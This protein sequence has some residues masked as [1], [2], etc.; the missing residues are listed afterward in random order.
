MYS[1]KF[2][3]S[4]SLRRVFVG[5]DIVLGPNSIL[6]FGPGGH[7]RLSKSLGNGSRRNVETR[8]F[9]RESVT[10]AVKY[11]ARIAGPRC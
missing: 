7:I 4:D 8:A 9:E 5:L 10:D 2:L 1:I 6:E 11:L 3:A